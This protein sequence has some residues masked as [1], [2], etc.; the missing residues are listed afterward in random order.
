[1]DLTKCSF[2]RCTADADE[3][4]LNQ[5]GLPVPVCDEHHPYF[6]GTAATDL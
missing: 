1:M 5:I 3:W 2:P 4:P 6:T